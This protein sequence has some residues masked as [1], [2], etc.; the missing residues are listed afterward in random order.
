MGLWHYAELTEGG[1]SSLNTLSSH[2]CACWAVGV[3]V[4]LLNALLERLPGH[5]TPLAMMRLA[6]HYC[7]SCCWAGSQRGLLLF[8]VGQDGAW[9]TVLACCLRQPAALCPH[10]PCL[11]LQPPPPGTLG[12][13]LLH[14]F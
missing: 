9:G 10:R 12:A 4:A 14:I 8:C 7:C 2:L 5:P 13:L 3:A 11:S 6:C 1:M